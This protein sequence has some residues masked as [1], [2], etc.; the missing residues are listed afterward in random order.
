MH[1]RGFV[2]LLSDHRRFMLPTFYYIAVVCAASAVG[3]RV[4]VVKYPHT[5]FTTNEKR[6]R[7]SAPIAAAEPLMV[8]YASLTPLK[9]E[10]TSTS[11]VSVSS[12]EWLRLPHNPPEVIDMD[13]LTTYHRRATAT[14]VLGVNH[15]LI[16]RLGSQCTETRR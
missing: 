3:G 8:P 7:R 11:V 6:Q 5:S 14:P 16:K 9:L 10:A 12:L 13:P 1:A 15:N 4:A 2:F